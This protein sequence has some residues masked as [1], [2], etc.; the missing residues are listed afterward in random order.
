MNMNEINGYEEVYLKEAEKIDACGYRDKEWED[1]MKSQ[2]FAFYRMLAMRDCD[3]RNKFNFERKKKT[4]LEGKSK[5]FENWKERSNIT[6]E[7]FLDALLWVC[8]DPKNGGKMKCQT[9]REIALTPNGIKKLAKVYDD[10]MPGLCDYDELRRK[11]YAKRWEGETFDVECGREWN[12][13]GRIRA[14]LK[15]TLNAMDSIC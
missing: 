15:I 9:T 1:R 2:K 3:V 6:K 14:N 11:G 4:V 8:S 13:L 7:E 5:I 12:A 10:G